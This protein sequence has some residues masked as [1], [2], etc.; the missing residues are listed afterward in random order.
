MPVHLIYARAANGVIGKDN[1]LPWHLPEDMAHFKQLTQGC[2]VVMGRKTWDS[3]PARF[4]PLPGRTNIVVTRQH[5][6]QAEGA[7]RAESLDAALAQCDP[8]QT[9]WVIGGAQIYAE[10]LP[11]ADRLEVTEIARDFEGDAHAPVL[12]KAWTE[13][14]RSDHVSTNG[15]PFSFVSYVRAAD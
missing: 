6:W 1:A 7:R 12:G 5:D 2:P 3:L 4:R 11:T 8:R 10:A 13:A 14:A 9:V 15:L